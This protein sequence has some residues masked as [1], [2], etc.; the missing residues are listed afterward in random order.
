MNR[1]KNHEKTKETLGDMYD[2]IRII[3]I[4]KPITQKNMVV[5]Y[6][7]NDLKITDI[8]FLDFSLCWK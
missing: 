8:I 3:C 7:D 4:N 5:I 2:T 1:N 6:T